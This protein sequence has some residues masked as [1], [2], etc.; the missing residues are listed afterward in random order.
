MKV[1]FLLFP[2]QPARAGKESRDKE[3]KQGEEENKAKTAFPMVSRFTKSSRSLLR[4]LCANAAP[5]AQKSAVVL[6]SGGLDSATAL[7]IALSEGLRVITLSFDYQQRHR[8]ELDAAAALAKKHGVTDHRV[9]KIDPTVFA[10]SSLTDPTMEVPKARST[11]QM[12]T[13]E[14]PS[15]YVPARNTLFLSYALALAESMK[16]SD[17]YIG[18]NAIDYSGYPDCRPEF[19]QVFQ[20]LADVGT[21]AGVEHAAAPQVRIPLLH[22]RKKEIIEKGLELGV[23]YSLTHSCYDPAPS[24]YPCTRCDS[25]LLRAE[26]FAELGFSADPVL[27]R[28]QREDISRSNS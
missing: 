7:A 12:V 13:T 15:T 19:F 3:A 4:H 24:G 2:K 28:F 21:K 26:A 17:I 11:S 8:H 1:F 10:G 6:L 20:M 22:L 16:A 9:A 25:C 14:I 18:A 23:D 27:E 5:P